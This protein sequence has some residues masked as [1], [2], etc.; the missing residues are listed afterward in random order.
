[1]GIYLQVGRTLEILDEKAEIWGLGKDT[2]LGKWYSDVFIGE[3]F[4]PYKDVYGLWDDPLYQSRVLELKLKDHEGG[5]LPAY[6]QLAALLVAN[7][8]V[9]SGDLLAMHLPERRTKE[10]V[11]APVAASVPAFYITPIDSHRLILHY[12]A[13][14]ATNNMSTRKPRGQRAVE[15]RWK[16][17]HE[18]VDNPD[19][20]DR[21]IVSTSSP[22]TMSFSPDDRGRELYI[23]MRW[24]NTRGQ[25]GPWSNVKSAAVP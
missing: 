24:E 5:L 19:S 1:M 2:P 15:I 7:P 6:R 11:K 10:Y 16:F 8:L 14:N 13:F 3:F 22:Y 20:F 4:K 9:G 21:T 12:H 25:T 17:S 23:A 18:P